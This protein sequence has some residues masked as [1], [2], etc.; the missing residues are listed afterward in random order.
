MKHTLKTKAFCMLLSLMLLMQ[1]V[2]IASFATETEAAET[3]GTPFV[4]DDTQEETPTVVCELKEKRSEY[5]KEFLLDDGSYYSVTTTYPMHSLNDEAWENSSDLLDDVADANTVDEIK[6]TIQLASYDLAVE[7]EYDISESVMTLSVDDEST[8][9]ATVSESDSNEEYSEIERSEYVVNDGLEIKAPYGTDAY[10]PEDYP[11]IYDMYELVD[12]DGVLH[13]LF[14]SF[15]SYIDNNMII[16]SADLSFSRF[17]EDDIECGYFSSVDVTF[18]E[19][20]KTSEI[21]SKIESLNVIDKYEISEDGNFSVDLTDLCNKWDLKNIE[22]DGIVIRMTSENRAEN[23]YFSLY[24]FMFEIYYQPINEKDLDFTYHSIDMGNA[25]TVYVNNYTNSIWTENSLIDIES[26]VLPITLSRFADGSNLVTSNYA[27]FGFGWNIESSLSIT[28]ESDDSNDGY[29]AI[30][31]SFSGE[32]VLFLP[33]STNSTEGEYQ[34]WREFGRGDI[35]DNTSVN[36]YILSSELESGNVSYSNVYLKQGDTTY[37]FDDLGHVVSIARPGSNNADAVVEIQYE[38]DS[39]GNI[40]EKIVALTNEDGITYDFSYQT[41]SRRTYISQ[42]SYDETCV[43]SFPISKV[44]NNYVNTVTSSNG[45]T[46]SYTFSSDG[47]LYRVINNNN[48]CWEFEYASYVNSESETVTLNRLSQYTK[49]NIDDEGGETEEFSVSFSTPNGYYREIIKDESGSVSNEIIQYDR[50]H[51]IITHKDFNGKYICAEYDDNGI[52]SSFAFNENTESELITN[53]SFEYDVNGVPEN[54]TLSDNTVIEIV[55]STWNGNSNVHGNSEVKFYSKTETTLNVMQFVNAAF[56]ADN[57]YVVGAWVKVNNTISDKERKIGV[58]VTDSEGNFITFIS[59]DNDL[60]NEWQYKLQAFKLDTK[61]DS[62]NINFTAINQSGEIRFDEITLFEAVDSQ[63]DLT[64]I[65]T[66]SPITTTYNED[67]TVSSETL[68]DGVYSMSQAYVYDNNG[69]IIETKDINGLTEY[70]QYSTLGKWVGTVKNS[71]GEIEDATQL[72]YDSYGV[73]Q[74]VSKTINAVTTGN[75][76]TIQTIYGTDSGKI[77]SV[78]HNGIEYS[79]EYN[80]NGTIN[81]IDISPKE[82]SD[83]RLLVEYGYTGTSNIGYIVYKNG[84]EV[85]YTYDSNGNISLVECLSV[86]YESDTTNLIKSYEYTYNNGALATSY[87]SETG[88][89]I[90]YSNSGYSLNTIKEDETESVE[91]YN[92]TV[93]ENGEAV[94]TFRQAYFTD[95]N[96]TSFDTITTSENTVSSDSST[97]N[98]TNY[99]SVTVEKN[100]S[101]D[102]FSTMDYSRASITDYFNRITNK[103][104]SLVYNTGNGKTY[105]VVS[106]TDYEYQLLDVGVTSGLISSYTTAIYG[107]AAVSGAELSEYESYS[108]KYEYD[109][110]GNIKYVY[111]QSGTTVSP[112]E[113]YEYDA[114]NQLVTSIDFSR[115]LVMQ[116]TYDAGGNLAS[117]IY[118]SNANLEFDYDNRTITELG[119]PYKEETYSYNLST[120]EYTPISYTSTDENYEPVTSTIEYDEMGNPKSYIGINIDNAEVTGNLEWNGNLL[121][122]FDNDKIRIEYQYD[123]NGYRSTKTVYEKTTDSNGNTTMS[124]TYKMTYIWDDGVLTNLLYAGGD[125]EELSLNIIYDQEGSPVGYVTSMGLPYYFIKDVNENVLGL[126]HA[127]GTKLCTIKYDAWGTP[128]YTYYGDNLLI[129]LLAKATAI[130]NPITYHGYIYDYETGMYCSQGR[131]YSPKWGRYLNPENPTSLLEYSEDVLDAN[132][133]L[134]CNNNPISNADPYASWSRD[135]IEPGW[136]ARGFNVEMNELFAS[137]S[138]CTVFANQ[139]LKEY[140]EWDAETGYTYLGMDTLRIASDLFAHYVGKHAASSINKVNAIWGE[141]WLSK[142]SQ[143]DVITIKSNDTNAWKYEKVWYAAPEIKA[144]AWSEG[145][146]ITL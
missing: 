87:D 138:F 89:T 4:T 102:K 6:E 101:D 116:Y 143:A 57:T 37:L 139:F 84:Y 23:A 78:Y 132:L 64:N 113:Y 103:N 134:F 65:V 97:G 91:L 7:N 50:N 140:G 67:G 88:Y 63:A 77:S 126:I 53:A 42:I 136:N 18:L 118:Y 104:T 135:Y 62:L 92:K 54:W 43:L 114:A 3:I 98:V 133:Y 68:T 74:T 80:Q 2:P 76:K 49:I 119:E 122:A 93:N 100:A 41:Y 146:F 145:V 73:L 56:K 21:A 55:P 44:S 121:S 20:T 40:T 86:D 36:L 85:E 107:D 45:E 130:F 144:Y 95:S 48:E 83:E 96:N 47:K 141:G 31:N 38:T 111:E 14:G 69:N 137:R 72:T 71:D 28:L 5:T 75:N 112:K 94:E 123:L 129:K 9:V 13:V 81:S 17:F 32:K 60:D 35:Q 39:N 90:V 115:G 70:Y 131:C 8:Y 105:N 24:N 99:S 124:N 59:F 109:N 51:N 19:G 26:D 142:C 22:N 127:D 27:G 125:C 108:R 117:K 58:E 11:D 10:S 34:I 52:I 33:D 66:S 12:E 106:E 82:S 15:G 29:K 120:A 25:G 16:K 110:K 1:L 30:W 46:A 61:L 128:Y 79:F